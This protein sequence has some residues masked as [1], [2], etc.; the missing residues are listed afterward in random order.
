MVPENDWN[1]QNAI[2]FSSYF[3]IFFPS[4]CDLGVY[5]IHHFETNPSNCVSL[6]LLSTKTLSIHQQAHTHT[7]FS[8]SPHSILSKRTFDIS[9][10]L[11]NSRLTTKGPMRFQT[12]LS[13]HWWHAWSGRFM[14]QTLYPHSALKEFH[15]HFSAFFEISCSFHRYLWHWDSSK[16]SN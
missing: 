5:G 13:G 9:S 2:I 15:T 12:Q 14:T 10:S 11:P 1:N 6:M 8:M 16:C 3:T 4:N 7:L